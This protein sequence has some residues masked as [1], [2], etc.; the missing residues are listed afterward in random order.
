M[1]FWT[2]LAD[3]VRDI[4]E[5]LTAARYV[6]KMKV[7]RVYYKFLVGSGRKNLQKM[8]QETNSDIKVPSDEELGD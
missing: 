4:G 5:Q 8:M 6:Y 1:T 2:L 7:A 3:L